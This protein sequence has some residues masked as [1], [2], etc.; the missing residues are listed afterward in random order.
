MAS[1]TKY[2]SKCKKHTNHT[3]T[4]PRDSTRNIKGQWIEVKEWTYKC[5]ECKT[6]TTSWTRKYGS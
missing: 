4:G 6:I 3:I 5:G 1:E 2:C